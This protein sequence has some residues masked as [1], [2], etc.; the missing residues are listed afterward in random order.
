MVEACTREGCS[1]LPWSKP[2]EGPGW[3]I[4]AG[5][6]LEWVAP[7][8]AV[9]SLPGGGSALGVD[10]DSDS[11]LDLLTVESDPGV[12]TVLVFYRGTDDGL[13]SP[14]AYMTPLHLESRAVALVDLDG[15]GSKEL[16][17]VTREGLLY[18]S[19]AA[20]EAPPTTESSNIDTGLSVDTGLPV[21]TGMPD[22]TGV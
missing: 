7:D 18:R 22:D 6:V 2:G 5:Q 14:E 1:V 20:D 10:M 12:G 3:V 15:L 16:W 21:D 11:Q 13:A 17:A 8:G 4:S 9:T 19:G